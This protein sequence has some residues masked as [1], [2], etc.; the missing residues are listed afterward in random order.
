MHS[1]SQNLFLHPSYFILPPSVLQAIDTRANFTIIFA[2]MNRRIIGL[3]KFF[4]AALVGAV[5]FLSLLPS[6]GWAW[7]RV[8]PEHEHWFVGAFHDDVPLAKNISA[9]ADCA[10]CSP[11]ENGAS[12]VHAPSFSAIQV[13]AIAMGLLSQ[14]VI[15]IP[16]VFLKTSSLNLLISSLIFCLS[17]TLLPN[18]FD[19]HAGSIAS[20]TTRR[21][22]VQVRAP[23]P[24]HSLFT[25]H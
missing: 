24:R 10:E 3:Q 5:L 15:A 20:R 16:E 21:H 18:P 22:S 2:T 23:S 4:Y 9:L 17:S 7:H 6:L 13:L 19:S 1:S 12:V 25:V 14:F 11:T 8:L